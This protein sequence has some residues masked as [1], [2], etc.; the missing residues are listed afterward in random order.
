MSQEQALTGVRIL[1]FSQV[2]QGLLLPSNWLNW[3][4]GDQNNSLRAAI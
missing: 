4:A 3:G 2:L 1:D